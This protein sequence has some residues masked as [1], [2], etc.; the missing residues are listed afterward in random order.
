ME[1]R[2]R[3]NGD[4]RRRKIGREVFWDRAEGVERTTGAAGRLR[5]PSLVLAAPGCP[6]P[7]GQWRWRN[8]ARKEKVDRLSSSSAMTMAT[9]GQRA[10]RHEPINIFT[11]P[12]EPGLVLAL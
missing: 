1:V 4:G 6:R 3:R 9:A 7:K 12:Q 5:W 11:R 10:N 2:R 8:R